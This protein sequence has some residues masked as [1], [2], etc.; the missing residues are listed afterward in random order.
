MN[1]TMADTI[2]ILFETLSKKYKVEYNH[3]PTTQTLSV[4]GAIV[5]MYEK[6]WLGAELICWTLN[7][8]I[9]FTDLNDPKTID[10]I[11]ENIR[12][13]K[14]LYQLDSDVRLFGV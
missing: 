9:R 1:T 5:L 2:R 11:E 8:N 12:L 3:H 6:T 14:Q 10:I 4:N 7:G 13:F